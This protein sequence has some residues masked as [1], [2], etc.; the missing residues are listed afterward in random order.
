MGM[1]KPVATASHRVTSGGVSRAQGSAAAGP[2]ALELPLS[3]ATGGSPPV[4]SG[5]TERA[6][7]AARNSAEGSRVSGTTFPALG[8]ELSFEFGPEVAQEAAC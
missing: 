8:A 3:A 1:Q 2:G 7:S 5:A 6:T 4:C